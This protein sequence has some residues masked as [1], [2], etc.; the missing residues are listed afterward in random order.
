MGFAGNPVDI[1]CILG[2][3][4]SHALKARARQGEKI[5]IEHPLK[6]TVIG[7]DGETWQP[8]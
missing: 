6:R 4:L 5:L 7:I 2:N 8:V 3:L 1:E